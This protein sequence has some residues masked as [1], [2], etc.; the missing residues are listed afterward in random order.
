MATC[1]IPKHRDSVGCRYT[2]SSKS[3]RDAGGAGVERHGPFG[4][5]LRDSARCV[6]QPRDQGK[7]DRRGRRG[8]LRRSAC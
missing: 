1:A 8:A 6:P 4:F 3:R 2:R 5:A 7:R